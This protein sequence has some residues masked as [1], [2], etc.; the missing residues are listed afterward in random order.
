MV[1]CSGEL[2]EFF[3]VINFLFYVF[4]IKFL[5]VVKGYIFFWFMGLMMFW[6]HLLPYLVVFLWLSSCSMVDEFWSSLHLLTHCIFVASE[7]AATFDLFPSVGDNN[8]SNC[9]T[10]CIISQNSVPLWNL[11]CSFSSSSL[12][13]REF[14]KMVISLWYFFASVFCW[15]WRE[16]NSWQQSRETVYWEWNSEIRCFTFLFVSQLAT[17]TV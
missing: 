13:M 16:E 1:K 8:R 9:H 7:I 4:L 14:L 2:S 15:N 12:V 6:I 10:K 5:W 11:Y 17:P 3:L